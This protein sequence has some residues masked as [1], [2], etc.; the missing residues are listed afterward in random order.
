MPLVT[1]SRDPAKVSDELITRL[2]P[3]L[4]G[5]FA[6]TLDCYRGRLKRADIEI[7]VR[8]IG[9]LDYNARP[10]QIEVLASHYWSRAHNI[11]ER[12]GKATKRIRALGVVPRELIGT[13]SGFVWIVL[14]KAG[15]AHL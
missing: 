2:S 10:L 3:M 8:D 5:I 9:R 12:T 7:R 14:G 1:I 4:Q 15:F 11:D 6:E 13:E